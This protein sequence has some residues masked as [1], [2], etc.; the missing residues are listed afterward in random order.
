VKNDEQV[1]KP[2]D[3]VINSQTIIIGAG[4]AGLAVAACLRQAEIPF[5]IIE[6]ADKVG[7]SW[8]RHYD[9]L[10]LHTDKAHSALP[11]LPFPKHYPRYPSR[12]QVVTYLKTYNRHF[13]LEPIF[14]EAVTAAHHI[15]GCWEVQTPK[16]RYCAPHLIIATGHNGEPCLPERPGQTL[17]RGKIIHSSQYCNGE[18]FKGQQVLVVGFGNSGGEIAIDLWESGAHPYM[19]VRNPVNIIPRQLFGIPIL[20]LSLLSSKLPPKLADAINAPLLNL[21]I[22]DLTQY[23][24]RKPT[25]GPLTQIK[26]SGRIPLIDVGTLKLIRQGC[27]NIFPGVERFT[28]EGIVFTDGQNHKFDAVV[29]ATG[30]RPGVNSFLQNSSAVLDPKGKPLCSGCETS[31]PGLY[32]CGFYI[33]PTGMLREIAIEAKRISADILRKSKHKFLNQEA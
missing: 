33:S 25:H 28:E 11:Y 26:N 23:G 6:Q 22:G 32:F 29:L 2:P 18:P 16:A 1:I 8:H 14:G 13:K 15:N 3:K 12:E 27:I 20:A 4:P 30:Y 17:F 21:V 7:A 24:L 19:A 9:R 31:L 10:H 5:I